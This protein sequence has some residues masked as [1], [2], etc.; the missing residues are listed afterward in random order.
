MGSMVELERRV[1]EL[2]TAAAAKGKEKEESPVIWAMELGQCV[3]AAPSIELAEVVVT[4]LCFRHN[5]PCRWK[6]IDFCLSSGLL[7]PLHVLSLLSSRFTPLQK[8]THNFNV[9]KVCCDM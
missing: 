9:N 1:V 4:Q 6:F 7:S 5:K 2:V 3:E 8:Q